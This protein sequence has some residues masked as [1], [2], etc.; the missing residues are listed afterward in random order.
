MNPAQQPR[1]PGKVLTGTLIIPSMF[2]HILN[3]YVLNIIIL[4]IVSD[5]TPYGV[6]SLNKALPDYNR[7]YIY[8][9]LKNEPELKNIEFIKT[10]CN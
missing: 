6:K 5:L 2:R 7:S 9:L 1:I 4:N 8:F 3:N 10:I